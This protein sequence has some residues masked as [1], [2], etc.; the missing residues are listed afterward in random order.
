MARFNTTISSEHAPPKPAG[1]TSPTKPPMKVA[2]P[3]VQSLDGSRCGPLLLVLIIVAG[4]LPNL[5]QGHRPWKEVGLSLLSFPLT[6]SWSGKL[7]TASD[8]YFQKP[9]GSP[10]ATPQPTNPPP[11]VPEKP[12]LEPPAPAETSTPN[13]CTESVPPTDTAP[14]TPASITT[15]TAIEIEEYLDL[16]EAEEEEEDRYNPDPYRLQR[17]L[18]INERVNQSLAEAETAALAREIL[19]NKPERKTVQFAPSPTPSPHEEELDGDLGEGEVM[20]KMVYVWNTFRDFATARSVTGFEEFVPEP[21]SLKEAKTATNTIPQSAARGVVELPQFI[22]LHGKVKKLEDVAQGGIVEQEKR[23]RVAA[24]ADSEGTKTEMREKTE[25]VSVAAKVEAPKAVA[26]APKVESQTKEPVVVAPPPAS[27]PTPAP[28]TAIK[29]VVTAPT[30]SPQPWPAVPPIKL[31]ESHKPLVPSVAPIVQPPKVTPALPLTP[32]PV[33]EEQPP[34]PAPA[35]QAVNYV[36]VPA[37][38]PRLPPST[39]PKLRKDL[40]PPNALKNRMETAKVANTWDM[41]NIP[42]VKV[43]MKR[44]GVE[45]AGNDEFLEGLSASK[46]VEEKPVVKKVVIE[47]PKPVEIDS[48]N[49]TVKPPVTPVAPPSVATEVVPTA[50]LTPAPAAARMKLPELRLAAAAA[51]ASP[52]PTPG[53]H[54][55]AAIATPLPKGPTFSPPPSGFSSAHRSGMPVPM[56]PTPRPAIKSPTKASIKPAAVPLKPIL[57]LK[58]IVAPKPA[59]L[60]STPKPKATISPIVGGLVD[61]FLA[62]LQPTTRREPSTPVRPKTPS[63]SSDSADSTPKKD[64]SPP[65][66]SQKGL[67]IETPVNASW[68]ESAP[69]SPTSLSSSWTLIEKTRKD[70]GTKDVS[71]PTP[72]ASMPTQAAPRKPWFSSADAKILPLA[73]PLTTTPTPVP[74]PVVAPTHPT[75]DSSAKAVVPPNGR[76]L[77]TFELKVGQAIVSTPV[78]ELDNP[79]AVAESFAKEH[80]LES[81]LPG[82]RFTVDKI[83]GY[84]ETQF[85]DRKAE[86]EKR[87]AERRERTKSVFTADQQKL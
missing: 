42:S 15:S 7:A 36:P 80:N 3:P 55:F 6:N 52:P 82:G 43:S 65:P 47:E 70:I 12:P 31:A 2:I 78:H 27:I 87:R 81:R 1:I 20:T 19:F 77:F 34:K 48:A 64:D 54:S 32:K 69:T 46:K 14:N 71:P 8:P 49:V 84:F 18:E 59:N 37:S 38:Q 41:P 10:L 62:S 40:G 50:V 17:D 57:P 26:Q 61:P 28:T 66:T 39:Y 53:P 29:L 86:R 79:R 73:S 67:K 16:L 85:A 74:T 44:S 13:D 4:P 30:P 24:K 9:P 68:E 58:P 51:M 21:R 76:K 56:P 23:E 72:P 63:Y 25:E 11:P 75:P 22:I 83:I 35:P 33:V 60:V 5:A 45:D